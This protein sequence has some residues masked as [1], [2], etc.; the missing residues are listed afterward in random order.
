[1]STLLKRALA[2]RDSEKVVPRRPKKKPDTDE[3]VETAMKAH[4]SEWSTID[5]DVRIV[6][7]FTLRERMSKDKRDANMN[8]NR[9]SSAYWKNLTEEYM[10]EDKKPDQELEV[11]HESEK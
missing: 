9:L 1:M 8:K 2:R 3:Q 11:K 7:G 4:F 6:N 5:T 10:P